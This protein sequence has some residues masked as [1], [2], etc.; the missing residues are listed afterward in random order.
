VNLGQVIAQLVDRHHLHADAVRHL[1]AQ[2]QQRLFADDLRADLALGLI[3]HHVVREVF[4]P[5]RQIGDDQLFQLV[6]TLA[7][8]RAD[9]HNRVVARLG[10]GLNR[11]HQPRFLDDIGLVEHQNL[12]DLAGA[13]LLDNR[14]ILRADFVCIHQHQQHVD[15]V[16]R[17]LHALD[18]VFAQ[19]RARL[20]QTRRIEE[21][22]LPALVRRHTHDAVARR[23][24]AVGD[25]GDLFADHRVHQGGFADVRAAD[26]RGEARKKFCGIFVFHCSNSL[27]LF[28]PSV[29]LRQ[30]AFGI[31]SACF[32]TD[33]RKCSSKR[34]VLLYPSNGTESRLPP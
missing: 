11:R 18:H 17:V 3:G 30:P 15:A 34:K 5:L 27:Y 1:L 26:N 10:E 20:M 2:M 25:D 24:R 8:A 13:H 6:H 22:D 9:G 7:R 28:S 14:A 31:S 19:A 33:S 12:L 29:F 32:V 16:H 4:R 21:D 23:L